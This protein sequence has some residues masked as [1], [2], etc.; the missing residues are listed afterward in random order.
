MSLDDT[1]R[2]Q[3]LVLEDTQT[4]VVADVPETNGAVQGGREE[5]SALGPSR[6]PRYA[7]TQSCSQEFSTLWPLN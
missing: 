7:T 6:N 1:L 3:L 2:D 5:E 4:V